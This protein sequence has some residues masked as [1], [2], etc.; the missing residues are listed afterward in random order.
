MPDMQITRLRL[1][2]NWFEELKRL[3]PSK[4]WQNRWQLLFHRF[5]EMAERVANHYG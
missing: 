4:L 1:V 2:Q 3:C 5:P